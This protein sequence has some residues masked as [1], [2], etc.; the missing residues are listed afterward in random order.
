MQ[1]GYSSYGSVCAMHVAC[2]K[3]QTLSSKD[4]HVY[5]HT[6]INK[7]KQ[8]DIWNENRDEARR[9]LAAH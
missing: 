1:E 8:G 6:K 7:L 5:R 2:C 9:W 4:S 3:K